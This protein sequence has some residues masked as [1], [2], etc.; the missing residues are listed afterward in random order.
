MSESKV[1]EIVE[2]LERYTVAH[3]AAEEAYMQVIN[4]PQFEEHKRIHQ[5]F[6]ARV[7][8]EK[9]QVINGE[10]LTLGLVTF[11]RQWL[12]DHILK[13]DKAFVEYAM[14]AQAVRNAPTPAAE[15]AEEKPDSLLK[16]VFKRFF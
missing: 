10:P 5:M 12:L 15:S 6:V 14:R 2:Q 8:K 11:L 1:L 4:Y 7:A 16:R 9:Q 3:F 13:T